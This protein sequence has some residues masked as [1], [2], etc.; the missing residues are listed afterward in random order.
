MDVL[1]VIF[2]LA[3]LCEWLS[4]RFFGWFLGGMSM[5]FL[6]T[7]VGIALA[8]LF[9][10]DGLTLLGLPVPLWAPWTGRILTGIIIGAGSDAVHQWFRMQGGRAT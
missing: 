5:V 9:Q 10:V 7:L 3:L 1:A 2:L 6:S 4:E 8:L